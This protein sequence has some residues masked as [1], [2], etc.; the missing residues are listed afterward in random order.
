M[1]RSIRYLVIATAMLLAITGVTFYG[2]YS[3]VVNFETGYTYLLPIGMGKQSLVADLNRK[4]LL[5]SKWLFESYVLLHPKA[6]LKAGEYFFPP[7]ST[8]HSIWRQITTGRGLHYRSFVLI[9]GWT[10]IQLR[11]E[12]NKIPQLRHATLTLTEAQIMQRVGAPPGVAAE[13]NFCPETYFYTIGSSDTVI[14]KRAYALM[15]KKLATLWPSRETNLPYNDTYQAL[16][17]ASLVEKEAHLAAERPIIAGVLM[18]RLNQNML[19]QFDPTVIYGMGASYTGKIYKSDL[20]AD[21]PYNTYV[22]KGLPPTPIAMPSE[23][24]LRAVLHPAHH[25]YLY[26]VAKGDGGHRFSKTLEEH[27]QAV[28]YYMPHTL[29]FNNAIIERYIKPY[30]TMSALEIGSSH[31]TW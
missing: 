14:L 16:I 19:L 12:L 9:P 5:P 15:Q 20:T 25:E 18:N 6:Q 24:S 23:S 11:D 27:H 28:S 2:L 22:H 21:T 30:L 1:R 17:A 29:F 26:F 7:G 4:Q 8:P 10:F 31:A 13:G 3:P